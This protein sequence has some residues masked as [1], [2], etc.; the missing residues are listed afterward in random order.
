MEE[1]F[2]FIKPYI[3]NGTL[4]D[5][6]FGEGELYLDIKEMR[7][8]I[9]QFYKSNTNPDDF[10]KYINQYLEDIEDQIG[11]DEGAYNNISLEDLIEDF[12][13]YIDENDLY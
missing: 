13:I 7:K 2:N 4:E 12:R 10:L 11:A 5:K 8:I 1:K 9:K 6:Y 3:K